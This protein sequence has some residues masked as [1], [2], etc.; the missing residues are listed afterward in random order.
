MDRTHIARMACFIASIVFV[1][2]S[3]WSL[4]WVFSSSDMAF[5]ACNGSFS[6]FALNFRCRQPH[7]AMLLSFVSFLF[8]VGAFILGKR[9]RRNK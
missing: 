2:V 3:G 6:L 1:L 8:A 9:Y 5:A 4:V 7:I